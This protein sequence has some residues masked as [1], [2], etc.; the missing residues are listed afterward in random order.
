MRLRGLLQL[1]GN[2]L[3]SNETNGADCLG[4]NANPS[5]TRTVRGRVTSERRTYFAWHGSDFRAPF[6]IG[7]T[8][9]RSLRTV[10]RS[11]GQ[12]R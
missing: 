10:L 3:S 7:G 1:Y 11:G 9:P 6:T 4:G 2:L 12:T 5:F 8:V